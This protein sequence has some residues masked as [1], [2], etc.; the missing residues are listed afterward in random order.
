LL[1]LFGLLLEA[2]I[3]LFDIDQRLVASALYY[4]GVDLEVHQV[5]DDPVLLFELQPN[6]QFTWNNP[7]VNGLV[8]DQYGPYTVTINS[9]G[10]RSPE[11]SI[12]KPEGVVRILSFG[13]STLYGAR[14]NDDETLPFYLEEAL[15]SQFE[16]G[17]RYETWNFGV[18]SYSLR[19]EARLARIM[20]ERLNPDVI[21]VMFYFMWA[22]RAF[23][24]PSE[25]APPFD[26]VPYFEAD[27]SLYIENFPCP[28]ILTE[29]LHLAGMRHVAIYRAFI[30]WHRANIG[31]WTRQLAGTGPC[32]ELRQLES[33]AAR[34]DVQVVYFALPGDPNN[35]GRAVEECG[36]ERRE[37][38]IINE[39]GREEEYYWGHPPPRILREFGQTLADELHQLRGVFDP[40]IGQTGPVGNT[41]AIH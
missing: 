12:E 34:R 15:N 29:S 39:Q 25:D 5:S 16:S 35:G 24:L 41:T 11:Y 2:G 22:Q 13:P 14:V 17:P 19:Q 31:E 23:L 9:Q 10:A 30:G 33:E 4:Q 21:L 20:M 26:Y 1:V 27:P 3:R 8:E 28:S 36:L 40:E 32:D 37:F 18:S 6:A 38:I 7:I